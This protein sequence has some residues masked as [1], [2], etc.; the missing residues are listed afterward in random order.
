[1]ASARAVLPYRRPALSS[2]YAYF[3]S[4]STAFHVMGASP[5]CGVVSEESVSRGETDGRPSTGVL[6]D[7]VGVA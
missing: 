3:G 2:Y 4:V 1:M 7:Q 6:H 5:E